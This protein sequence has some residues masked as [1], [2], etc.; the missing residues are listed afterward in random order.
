MKRKPPCS[1]SLWAR[2]PWGKWDKTVH[3]TGD[4]GSKECWSASFAHQYTH[5][6][7]QTYTHG[8]NYEWAE[9][10][11]GHHA[12]WI[13]EFSLCIGDI[14]SE[15]HDSGVQPWGLKMP[16]DHTFDVVG[17]IFFSWIL[18][19]VT[20]T[21]NL[22]ESF[23]TSLVIQSAQEC[24]LR[25]E[26]SNSTHKN[27]AARLLLRPCEC[28]SISAKVEETILWCKEQGERPHAT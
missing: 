20:L 26:F 27:T 17:E 19:S 5:L 13:F 11:E 10:I 3:M 24:K 1:S 18:K 9:S 8:R 4:R 6:H 15:T 2:K 14:S 25:K 12:V 28:E 21:H 16:R 22:W 23:P 7:R